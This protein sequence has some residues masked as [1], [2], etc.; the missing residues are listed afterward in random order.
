MA[1]AGIAAPV[2]INAV[3]VVAK[4]TGSP[5]SSTFTSAEGSPIWISRGPFALAA[6]SIT[7]RFP[8]SLLFSFSFAL[9]YKG[10]QAIA[11]AIMKVVID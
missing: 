7:L 11:A 2:G 6:L 8:S 4:V 10:V 9:A 5:F 3:R 1:V